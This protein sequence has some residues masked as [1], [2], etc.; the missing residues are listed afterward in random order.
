MRGKDSK[1]SQ[2][3]SDEKSHTARTNKILEPHVEQ[4]LR[5]MLQRGRPA[6]SSAIQP[7]RVSDREDPQASSGQQE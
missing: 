3:V 6:E 7:V 2:R 4:N 5:E 1:A